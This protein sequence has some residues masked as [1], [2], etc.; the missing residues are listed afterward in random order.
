MTE[1]WREFLKAEMANPIIRPDMNP[2]TKRIRN[3]EDCYK[4][5]QNID[6][7][8]DSLAL[9]QKRFRPKVAF[10]RNRVAKIL[11]KDADNV[12][13]AVKGFLETKTFPGA[14]YV[15][16]EFGGENK[17]TGDEVYFFLFAGTIELDTKYLKGIKYVFKYNNEYLVDNCFVTEFGTNTK[18]G[19]V[20]PAHQHY[21]KLEVYGDDE[22]RLEWFQIFKDFVR[23]LQIYGI[24]LNTRDYFGEDMARLFEEGEE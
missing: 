24:K 22:D 21:K 6:K 18:Y 1:D 20:K 2:P 19:H 3:P 4:I 5:F 7:V 14:R 17:E 11:G 9:G 16:I 8:V 10:D 12:L 23:Q 15:N 13:C